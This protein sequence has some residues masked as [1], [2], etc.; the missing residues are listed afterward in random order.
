VRGAYTCPPFF[1]PRTRRAHTSTASRYNHC[2]I[3]AEKSVKYVLPDGFFGTQILQNSFRPGLSP[4]PRWGRL[5]RS[6]YPLP[7]LNPQLIT[8]YLL[9]IQFKAGLGLSN[10]LSRF[11]RKLNIKQVHECCVTHGR[12]SIVSCQTTESL[13]ILCPCV[14]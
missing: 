13:N 3:M 9:S 1:S 5:R 7:V 2:S 12:V 14:A 11:A 10:S 4:R 8:N 6:P